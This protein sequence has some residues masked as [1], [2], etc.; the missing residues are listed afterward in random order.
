VYAAVAVLL[1]LPWQLFVWRASATFPDELRGSYGPYLEWVVGG[2]RDGGWPFLSAVLAKNLEATRAMV[3]IFFSPLVAGPVRDLLAVLATATFGAGCAVLAARR[4]APVTILALLGYLAVVIAWPFWVD[5]FL[6][7]LW[8]VLVLIAVAGVLGARAALLARGRPRAAGAVVAVGLL[9]ALGHTTYNARGLPRGWAQRASGEMTAA[10][11]R[12]VRH[13]ND[14]RSLDGRLLAAELAPLVALYTGARVLPVEILTPRE[15]VVEK[16][17]AERVNELERIDRRFRPEA[18]VVMEAGPYYRA[19][20][21]ATLDSGRTL[22]DVSAP[23][24]PVRT[25]LASTP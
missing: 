15:H 23:G 16:T 2:Y 17:D 11:I 3:G 9:L 7:V 13:I 8:P 22:R 12:I 1:L 25:L 19:L 4:R 20:R 18:Y 24:A 21:A 10:A 14:D 5:R 6:W